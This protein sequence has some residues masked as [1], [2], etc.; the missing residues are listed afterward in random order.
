MCI[1]LSNEYLFPYFSINGIIS[2]ASL[3][4]SPGEDNPEGEYLRVQASGFRDIKFPAVI[5]RPKKTLR[6]CR[7][8]CGEER[9]LASEATY[10]A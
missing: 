1:T 6:Y 10:D 7:P 4:K 9:D 2:P 8:G 5:F 3:A